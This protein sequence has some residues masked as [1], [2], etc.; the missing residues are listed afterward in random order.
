MPNAGIHPI[1]LEVAGA[2][3]A[4]LWRETVFLNHLPAADP[5]VPTGQVAVKLVLALDTGPALSNE[6]TPSLGIDE[7]ADVSSAESLYAA[8]PDAPFSLALRPNTLDALSRSTETND[9]HFVE[10]LALGRPSSV[11]D[12]LPYVRVD[13]GGLIAA[14]ASDEMGRQLLTGA[15]VVDKITGTVP[16]G[17]DW[18]LDDTVTADSLAFLR[19]SGVRRIIVPA[20]RLRIPTSLPPET[21]WTRTMG[22][23]AS[24]G[25]TV[26]SYDQ[27]LTS[28]LAAA[29][30][31]PAVRAHQVVTDLMATWF[32]ASEDAADRF[33]GPSSIVV[34][35]PGTDPEVIRQL[36][37]AAGDQ[38]TDQH[39]CGRGAH[40]LRPGTAAANRRHPRPPGAE[41][42]G[43][44]RRR[45]PARRTG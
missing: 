1:E 36:A 21:A 33:P 16:D 8:V 6:L 19:N 45:T 5:A 3:G 37:A 29:A 13:V 28:R 15:Q 23:G 22:L 26:T 24:D 9:R 41:Q 40:Q 30:V 39:R 4:P 34:V 35:P 38:R 42:P 27:A 10:S 25:M 31:P 43:R 12:R 17:H 7:R 18:I 11:I 2:D 44:R 14:G 32:S 20:D